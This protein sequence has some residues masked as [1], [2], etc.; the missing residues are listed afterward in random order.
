MTYSRVSKH[1]SG[2]MIAHCSRGKSGLDHVFLTQKG[3]ELRRHQCEHILP[4]H[5]TIFL[6]VNKRDSNRDNS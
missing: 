4:R 2:I 1:Y 6:V 3:F 5:S